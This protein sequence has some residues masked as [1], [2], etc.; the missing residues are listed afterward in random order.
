MGAMQIALAAWAILGLLPLFYYKPEPHVWPMALIYG[1]TYWLV[2]IID[3]D[4]R[5]G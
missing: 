2:M 5:K 1:G 3:N 4:N